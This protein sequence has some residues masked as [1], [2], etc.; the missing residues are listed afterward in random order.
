[1]AARAGLHLVERRRQTRRQLRRRSPV[2]LQQVVGDALRA[3]RTDA[4][5]LAQRVDQL[6]ESAATQ[7]PSPPKHSIGVVGMP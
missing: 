4:R 7:I 3:L 2:V 1:M 6:I 5:Q